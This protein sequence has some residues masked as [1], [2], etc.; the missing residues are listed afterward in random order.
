MSTLRGVYSHSIPL[1]YV[2][3]SPCSSM[4]SPGINN[5]WKNTIGEHHNEEKDVNRSHTLDM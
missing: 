1:N 2:F 3:E 4:S 5:T